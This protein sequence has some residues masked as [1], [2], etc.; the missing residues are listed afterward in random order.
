MQWHYPVSF[1]L[2]EKARTHFVTVYLQAWNQ[3]AGD[4]PRRDFWLIVSQSCAC[5]SPRTI[6][7]TA[8]IF[9]KLV[10]YQL[11]LKCTKCQYGELTVSLLYSAQE[12][13]RHAHHASVS[14]N[15]NQKMSMNLLDTTN[16]CSNFYYQQENEVFNLICRY[17]IVYQKGYLDSGPV[18]SVVTTK[19]KG[20]YELSDNSSEWQQNCPDTQLYGA[21]LDHTDLVVPPQVSM[22]D[23]TSTVCDQILIIICINTHW[24]TAVTSPL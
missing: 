2:L 12:N 14:R 24:D 4:R 22:W 18:V 1:S 16:W 19:L 21:V 10:L 3:P 13:T 6:L 9:A 5:H 17:G 7:A 11:L 8:S 23:M 20:A 15:L